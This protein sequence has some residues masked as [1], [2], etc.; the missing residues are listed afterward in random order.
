MVLITLKCWEEVPLVICQ[1][2]LHERNHLER[3][4]DDKYCYKCF[5]YMVSFNLT[6]SVVDY[7]Y[8]LQ[9]RKQN[10]KEAK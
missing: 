4:D 10:N 1:F 9:M 3:G 2:Q 7:Y 8:C 6:A 5:E